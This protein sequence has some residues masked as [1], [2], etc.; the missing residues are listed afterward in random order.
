MRDFSR[1][2]IMAR[3]FN[4][5]LLATERKAAAVLGAIGRRFDIAALDVVMPDGS[6]N[7]HGLAEL[8]QHAASLI[9]GER[10]ERKIYSVIDGVAVI[11][12]RGSLVQRHGLDPWSGMTGYDGIAAKFREAVG[13]PEVRGIVFDVDSPGGEVAGCFDLVDEIHAARGAKPVR[14][15]LS[16]NA[17][18]AAYALASAA[19]HITVP[20]TGFAGS[21]GVI[22]MHADFSRMLDEEG[23]TVTLI[24]AGPHKADG[25]PFEPLPEAVRDEIQTDIDA[26]Y[27]L[28]VDTVAR[29]RSAMSPETV[30]GTE[31]RIYR[32]GAAVRVGL[33]D[34]VA[35]PIEAFR[36]FVEELSGLAP[37]PVA[38]TAGATRK[39]DPMNTHAEGDDRNDDDE[40]NAQ[41]DE[42]RM[43][44]DENA[45]G[46]GEDDEEDEGEASAGGDGAGSEAAQAE[47]RRIAGII[48]SKEAAQRQGLARHLA[49]HTG[50]SVKD[51]KAALAA[52]PL[53]AAGSVL[54]RAMA[55]QPNPNV[56]TS[57]GA[58]TATAPRID[59]AAIYADR[60]KAMNTRA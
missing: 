20:R 43:P 15:I 25:N 16:E 26:T 13:D 9:D 7:R 58:E 29:N 52:A 14:A 47:R 27:T 38:G 35:S 30:R 56:G 3:L 32:G 10:A 2:D 28:F 1:A 49:F 55:Q 41:D 22:C 11:P 37:M 54:A 46:E 36:A 23:V 53:E 51:A 59:T 60:R 12:V 17:M 48:D 4:T 44:D 45:Q 34:E 40:Q 18:S 6:V 8:E 24:F 33:A 57:G 21:V 42:K 5:P 19:D 31:S 50:M 39:G